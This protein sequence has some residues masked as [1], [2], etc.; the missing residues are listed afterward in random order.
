MVHTA[1]SPGWYSLPSHGEPHRCRWAYG[2]PANADLQSGRHAVRAGVQG[3]P[4]GR[5]LPRRPCGSRSHHIPGGKYELVRGPGKMAAAGLRAAADDVFST[6]ATELTR[7]L[8]EGGVAEFSARPLVWT[9]VSGAEGALAVCRAQRSMEP[10]E[11]V[12][13]ELKALIVQ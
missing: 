2:V 7:M 6:W 12:R 10:L 5:A 1:R 4:V 13:T 9:L 3:Q 8:Y 11:A